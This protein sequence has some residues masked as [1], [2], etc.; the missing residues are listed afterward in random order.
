MHWFQKRI[1]QSTNLVKFD[2]ILSDNQESA[3][4]FPEFNSTTEPRFSRKQ[5]RL[6][7]ITELLSGIKQ[8]FEKT[9]Q[10]DLLKRLPFC[11]TVG[12][13]NHLMSICSI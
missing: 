7:K 1:H 8:S 6:T 9:H 10:K 3:P 5:R 2:E 4:T 11:S 12:I 13:K